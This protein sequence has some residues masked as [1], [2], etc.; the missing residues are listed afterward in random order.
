MSRSSSPALSPW[1]LPVAL[2]AGLQLGLLLAGARRPPA[3]GQ[4][5]VL[6]PLLP[7][8][9]AEIEAQLAAQGLLL[10]PDPERPDMEHMGS[11]L[12]ER[13]G[14]SAW[15]GPTMSVDDFTQGL[16]QL[17]SQGAVALSEAQRREL[18]PLLERLRDARGDLDRSEQEMRQLAQQLA[19]SRERLLEALGPDLR[20][21]LAR[22]MGRPGEG[23][24]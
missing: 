7:L 9:G 16:A 10:P 13:L 3:S 4:V 15:L 8:T 18:E 11:R 2:L 20:A 22:R 1:W 19:C 23:A 6:L 12:A 5:Q 21:D 24:P 17:D 14:R